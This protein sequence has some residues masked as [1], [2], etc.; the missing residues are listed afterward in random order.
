MIVNI[1]F[2]NFHVFLGIFNNLEFE[3][4]V[5]VSRNFGGEISIRS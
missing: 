4:F 1:Q 3:M 2:K 5:N